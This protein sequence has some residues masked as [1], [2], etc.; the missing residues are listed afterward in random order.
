[1]APHTDVWADYYDKGYEREIGLLDDVM[2]V[3][4]GNAFRAMKM[5][6]DKLGRYERRVEHGESDGQIVIEKYELKELPPRDKVSDSPTGLPVFGEA[7]IV[8]EITRISSYMDM[9]CQIPLFLVDYLMEREGIE[10]VVELGS[11][12]GEKLVGLYYYGCPHDIRLYGAE[13]SPFG[14]EMNQRFVDA[15]KDFNASI[16]PFDFGRPDVLSIPE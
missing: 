14:R 13:Y 3:A 11:G 10:A 1:M 16:H 2:K 4:G 8:G 6:L 15:D 5:F 12:V 7:S 9:S